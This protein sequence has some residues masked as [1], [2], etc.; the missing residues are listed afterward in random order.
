VTK[1]M[2]LNMRRLGRRRN[3]TC[4][5]RSTNALA[6]DFACELVPS[7]VIAAVGE[8]DMQKVSIECVYSDVTSEGRVDRKGGT[9]MVRALKKG[10]APGFSPLLALLKKGNAEAI[11]KGFEVHQYACDL[12]AIL[13]KQSLERLGYSGEEALSHDYLHGIDKESQ[14][15]DALLAM[16]FARKSEKGLSAAYAEVERL[17]ANMKLSIMQCT[18]G[19][20]ARTLTMMTVQCWI[21]M[22]AQMNLGMVPAEEERLELADARTTGVERR[23]AEQSQAVTDMRA[24][25]A[26]LVKGRKAGATPAPA[27]PAAAA[28]A[29]V[30]APRPAPAPTGTV[31]EMGWTPAVAP[32]FVR[33][34]GHAHH[35]SGWGQPCWSCGSTEHQLRDCP[36]RP[37]GGKGKGKGKGGKG[38]QSRD[39]SRATVQAEAADSASGG[40]AEGSGNG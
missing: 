24:E 38:D 7:A 25:I 9:T 21:T 1:R 19:D 32:S 31:E 4:M 13:I 14:Y 18:D 33:D 8:L 37:A 26:L 15:L 39:N 17:I 27:G 3:T 20:A 11:H 6:R 23:L 28:T 5:W 2:Q 40:A 16:F 34:T 22:D 12:N 35:A 29:I 30:A 10:V 36:S